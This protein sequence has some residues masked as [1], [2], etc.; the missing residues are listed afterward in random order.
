MDWHILIKPFSLGLELGL[1]FTALVLFRLWREK[2]ELKRFKRHL[3]DKLEIEAETLNRLKSD[4]ESLRKENDNL[5]LQVGSM[6][7]SQEARLVRDLEIF[8]RAEKRMIVSA[9]GFAAA[10]ENAK[11]DAQAEL[12]EEEAGRSLPKRVF[13]KLFGAPAKREERALPDSSAQ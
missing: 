11:N 1:V 4:A 10:W 7:Q 8:A 3:S 5:R 13:T 9:P 2:G 6:N 12:A